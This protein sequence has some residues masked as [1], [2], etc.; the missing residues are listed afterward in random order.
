M[1]DNTWRTMCHDDAG[2][3]RDE[4]I[5]LVIKFKQAEHQEYLEWHEANKEKL[6][7]GDPEPMPTLPMHDKQ[8]ECIEHSGFACDYCGGKATATQLNQFM[9]VL[10]CQACISLPIESEVAQ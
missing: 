8:A 9:P 10:C 2:F 5:E 4:V 3:T 7:L 6:S 1:D